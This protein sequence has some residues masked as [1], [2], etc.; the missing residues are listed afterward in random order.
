MSTALATHSPDTGV[1]A[2]PRYPGSQFLSGDMTGG[3]A[4]RSVGRAASPAS[5][6]SSLE[7]LPWLT[8]SGPSAGAT[9]D[10]SDAIR[11]GNGQVLRQS[12]ILAAL[13]LL[14]GG[15]WYLGGGSAAQPAPLLPQADLLGGAPAANPS[16]AAKIRVA[17]TAAA[18]GLIATEGSVPV[19]AQQALIAA[20]TGA[21]PRAV[22]APFMPASGAR[23]LP[24]LARSTPSP[25]VGQADVPDAAAV[26]AAP[27]LLLADS[28]ATATTLTEYRSTVEQCRDAIRAVI[29]LGDRQRPGRSASIEEQ[30]GYRLR[31]QNAEAAKGY[32]SYLDTLAR[33]MRGAKSELVARQSLERARQT[34][35]YVNTML[36]DSQDSLH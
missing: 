28:P 17:D 21:E 29:R 22:A 3:A 16:D 8:Q 2:T 36:A 13:A 9:R 19:E 33:S 20:Q 31:L 4:M 32:R 35:G 10:D 27:P 15:A 14:C 26:I 18:T 30:T 34:L 5:A 1:V 11:P 25:T 24:P 7:A 12:G 6:L 23:T